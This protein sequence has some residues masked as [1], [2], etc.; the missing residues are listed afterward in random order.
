MALII[1][2]LFN[3][4]TTF[5]LSQNVDSGL[6]E[7]VQIDKTYN[8][9]L[10]GKNCVVPFSYEEM[11]SDS[12][13][14]DKDNFVTVNQNGQTFKIR[15]SGYK[16][17][18]G[19]DLGLY[20]ADA[21]NVSIDKVLLIEGDVLTDVTSNT[22][23]N[24][25]P[26]TLE[27]VKNATAIMQL[28]FEGD[29]VV[30]QY[31]GKRH[32]ASGA[33]LLSIVA[34]FVDSTNKYQI[35]IQNVYEN[36][37]WFRVVEKI[38]DS[39]KYQ[40]LEKDMAPY[41]SKYLDPEFEK[42]YFELPENFDENYSVEGTDVLMACK[43]S[44][45]QCFYVPYT[46][47]KDW[48]VNAKASLD[49]ANHKSDLFEC[50]DVVEYDAPT[51]TI[52]KMPV[53]IRAFSRSK[54]LG[55]QDPKGIYLKGTDTSSRK[56]NSVLGRDFEFISNGAFLADDNIKS[57]V[58]RMN[59]DEN[60]SGTYENVLF[61][62][63]HVTDE[64][65]D[66]SARN[67]L[68]EEGKIHCVYKD[69]S[70]C[71]LLPVSIMNNYDVTCVPGD[72]SIFNYNYPDP[73]TPESDTSEDI[74]EDA[75]TNTDL[76]KPSGPSSEDNEFDSSPQDNNSESL[77]GDDSSELSTEKNQPDN[78]KPSSNKA[79]NSTDSEKR[80]ENTEN[81]ENTESNDA[82]ENITIEDAQSPLSGLENP[83]IT[84]NIVNETSSGN[85][86]M[87]LWISL[88]AISVLGFVLTAT[89]DMIRSKIKK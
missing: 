78:H 30:T 77:S 76:K 35:K 38:W 86:N 47:N 5:A 42:L 81:N 79:T 7:N 67:P 82:S 89:L 75:S 61:V 10:V 45:D 37:Q 2:C 20:I 14:Y 27:I 48:A 74:S 84:E 56:V 34:D 17:A 71:F 88:L 18:K 50:T 51:L 64:T 6:N 31:D 25:K 28:H 69:Y 24:I 87:P 52:V 26:G 62:E 13:K 41:Q 21:T 46:L 57:V 39:E 83:A 40:I 63:N 29:Q 15:F 49:G 68:L 3:P 16:E 60:S 19:K 85:I 66:A 9:E 54:T 4:I 53:T 70:D 23:V 8:V 22:W 80:D 32:F 36:D 12:F 58:L 72:F 11:T 59:S 44:S 65:P 73:I 43:N 1:T 33:N 55:Q